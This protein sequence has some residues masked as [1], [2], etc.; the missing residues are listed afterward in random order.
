[1]KKIFWLVGAFCAGA[2]YKTH[3]D[4]IKKLRDRAVQETGERVGKRLW[5]LV[6]DD[7]PKPV[8]KYRGVTLGY[9]KE[10]PTVEQ[11]DHTEAEPGVHDSAHNVRKIFANP[12]DAHLFIVN[13]LRY[14]WDTMTVYDFHDK[15]GGCFTAE[16]EKHFYWTKEDL[17]DLSVARFENWFIVDFPPA[18]FG[19]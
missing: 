12:I 15:F 11:E 19:S 9:H 16:H 6:E 4:R 5:K 3:E 18:R 2:A 17:E 8:V 10:P 1:M 14:D 7:M 13:L